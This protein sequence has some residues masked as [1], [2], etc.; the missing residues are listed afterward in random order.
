[1]AALESAQL[2]AE[3]EPTVADNLNR[4]MA[5]ADEWMPHEYVPWS[6]GRDFAD[7]GGDPWEVAQSQLSPIARTALEVN[8][9][10]EDNLPSYHREID[11]AFGRTAPGAP[12]S[13]GGPP[14]RA[15]T[16]SASATT[17]WSPAGSIPTSSSGPGWR[18]WRSATR[19]RT[20][21]LLNVCAYVSFQELATRV[22]HRNT[23]P[24]HRGADR[25]EA[26]DPRRQGRE[27]AHDLLPQHRRRGA[28]AGAQPDDAGDHRG[29]RRLR[30]ARQ[31]HPGLLPQGGAD[32]Q[33]RAST[34]CASTTTTSSPRCCGSGGSWSS[35]ASTTTVRRRATS[36]RPPSPRSTARPPA[37]SS[38]APRRRPRR[39]P[40]SPDRP[41]Y[42]VACAGA[43]RVPESSIRHHPRLKAVHDMKAVTWQGVHDM[44]V[45][46]VPGPADRGADGRDHQ[47]HLDRA[48]RLRPAPLRDP[49]PVHGGRGRRRPR[50]DGHRRGGRAPGSPN[51]QVGD[52]VVVPFN[53]CCGT[54]WMCQ[55]KLYSQCETTQNHEHGTGAS[56]FGYSKLYGQVPGGQAEYL[57]VPFA[58]FLPVKVPHEHRR[59][60][61]PVP[62]RRAADGVAG[63]ASTPTSPTAAPCWCSAPGRS[64]TWPRGWASAPV[65]ASISVDRVPERL[66]RVAAFGAEPLD[67]D[68]AE[69]VG[70][71]GDVVRELTG[72][73]GPDA[74]ID[75]VGMEAHGSPAAERGAEVRGHAARRRL[76][77]ADEDRR[78]RPARGA[79][80]RDRRRP[81]R[82]HRSRS[83]GCTAAPRT[84]CR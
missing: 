38:G 39:P 42:D 20:S 55:R 43:P 14:R 80:H 81:S 54:C 30:D 44:Q 41:S 34:T 12:G 72:G 67:L 84:R 79:P 23:G 47:G 31:H 78:A 21:P 58:D 19:R 57:R 51:L 46:E 36:S 60:P 32:G 37:S 49:R 73:R 28:G 50:A 71:V 1:M 33:G 26:A 8:L 83:P 65:T 35:R 22:S 17:C 66:A 75:A 5:I 70:G 45:S 4:H 63:A 10:T 7:L 61:V 15:G 82:R 40:A 48:V 29:G 62:L 24:L 56:F 3:L 68:E 52:R 77:A 6:L 9:L 2:L 76:R 59:R 64:A 74:V 11:R 13:T 53:V 69:K 18:R 16:R 25:R 27:P